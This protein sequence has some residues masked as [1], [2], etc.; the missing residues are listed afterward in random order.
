[1]AI[2]LA[3]VDD[4]VIHGQTTTRWSVLRPVDSI[5]VIS[6]DV[7]K[8]SLRRKVV[9]AAAGNLKVG[10]YTVE[11]GV[12]ALSKVAKSTKNFFIISDQIEYFAELKKLGGDFGSE[13]NIGN[14]TGTREGTKNMG[15]SVTLNEKDYEACE[16]LVDQ[17]VDIQFQLLPDDE[18]RHWPTLKKKYESLT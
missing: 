6:D 10:I 5:L 9:K 11:Q 4:R 13:L 17:G 15:R 7:A 2:T 3:R 8:D 16:Y 18:I 1:M 14:L 12:E